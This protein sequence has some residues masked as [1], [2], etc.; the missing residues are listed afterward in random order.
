MIVYA[1]VLFVAS[2]A[3]PDQAAKAKKIIIWSLIGLVVIM[4]SYV[5]TSFVRDYLFVK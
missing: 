2:A 1:A 4:F 3:V 5:I